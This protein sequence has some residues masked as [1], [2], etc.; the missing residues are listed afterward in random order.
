MAKMEQPL[1]MIILEFTALTE[2]PSLWWK[3]PSCISTKIHFSALRGHSLISDTPY[4]FCR[5]VLLFLCILFTR[6][7][8]NC[9][10]QIAGKYSVLSKLWR[11]INSCFHSL[12]N[13]Y[14]RSKTRF[15]SSLMRLGSLKRRFVTSTIHLSFASQCQEKMTS[16]EQNNSVSDLT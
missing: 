1:D 10:F 8:S 6:A 14:K 5:R 3:L 12:W 2:Q 9:T 7:S 11:N 4:N 16:L 13:H 15:I